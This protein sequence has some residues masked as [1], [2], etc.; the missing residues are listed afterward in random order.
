MSATA[1]HQSDLQD[2]GADT[3]PCEREDCDE[4]FSEQ[5][6]VK[7][8]YCSRECFH[9]SKGANALSEIQRDHR[10]CATCFRQLKDVTPK[11]DLDLDRVGP[12]TS[13]AVIGFQHP[14]PE[15][16]HVVD[17]TGTTPHDRFEFGRLGCQCGNVDPSLRDETLERVEREAVLLNLLVCLRILDREG[18]V[19]N[20]PSKDRLFATL[21]QAGR[22]WE[23]AIGRAL[24]D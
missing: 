1:S 12:I 21:R 13:E 16:E 3:Y 19:A 8:S 7:G 11:S 24:Y 22:D 6:A 9:R 5:T 10:F 17:V 14:R 23:L 15:A 18:K 4:Q 2:W 20:R